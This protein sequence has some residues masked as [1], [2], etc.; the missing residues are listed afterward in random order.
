MDLDMI[1]AN[2]ETIE[3][4]IRRLEEKKRDS[5]LFIFPHIPR[6]KKTVTENAKKVVLV[7]VTHIFSLYSPSKRLNVG[8]VKIFKIFKDQ[9]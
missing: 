3:N 1:A 2:L 4:Q 5:E 8:D 7:N 6:H 9:T